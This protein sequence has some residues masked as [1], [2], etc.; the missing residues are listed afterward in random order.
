MSIKRF[1]NIGIISGIAAIVAALPSYASAQSPE[2]Q[3]ARD[4]VKA[5][6]VTDEFSQRLTAATSIVEL[7]ITEA[8]ET[9]KKLN[10]LTDSSDPLIAH[11]ANDLT[12]FIIANQAYGELVRTQL[13]Q[14]SISEDQLQA[15]AGSLKGWREQV[16]DPSMAQALNLALLNQGGSILSTAQ[17]RLAKIKADVS[18][19][20]RAYGKDAQAIVSHFDLATKYSEKAAKSFDQAQSTFSADQDIFLAKRPTTH[21]GVATAATFTRGVD[22]DFTC[23][24]QIAAS[25]SPAYKTAQGFYYTLLNADG[26][27][28]TISMSDLYRVSGTLL[29]L[30]PAFEGDGIRGALFV[31]QINPAQGSAGTLE[32]ASLQANILESA[33][34]V[35]DRET[36]QDSIKAELDAISKAYREFVTMTQLAKKLKPR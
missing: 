9:I 36:V 7:G 10:E 14:P 13:R 32:K 26:T 12:P 31:D 6:P 19:L 8:K 25:C 30:S 35:A 5:A 23:L 29:A 3:A 20:Q 18:V 16:Y 24:P 17:K 34:S 33:V 21:V 27:V 28:L 1:L 4:A 15:I 2:V 11:A 22:G